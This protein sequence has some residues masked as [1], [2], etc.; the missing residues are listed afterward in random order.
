MESAANGNRARAPDRPR[1][2]SLRKAESA[3]TVFNVWPIER[4]VLFG[5][6][7]LRQRAFVP[8]AANSRRNKKKRK[9]EK[10]HDASTKIL[11]SR[12]AVSETTYDARKLSDARLACRY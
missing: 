4:V 6:C 12:L 2:T 9:R 10:I 3:M 5:V 8:R 1:R 11:S 7:I